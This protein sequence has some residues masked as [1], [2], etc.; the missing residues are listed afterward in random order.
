[1][2]C[3]S[4]A[5]F[6]LRYLTTVLVLLASALQAQSSGPNQSA[7]QGQPHLFGPGVISTSDF[8]FNASFTPDGKTV[9][10]S[11]SD[12]GFNRITIV[13]SH[14]KGN[15]WT[16]PEVAPFSGIWKDTDPRVSPDGKKLFFTSNRPVDGSNTPKG[17]YDIWY[18]DRIPAK[19]WSE[20]KHLGAPVNSD[21]NEWYASVTREGTLYFGAERA[22]HPGTHIYRSRLVDGEYRPPELL[23]FSNQGNDLDPSIAA[24][25]SFVIFISRDRSG[26]GAG[27]LYVSFHRPDGTWSTPK[28]LGSPINSSFHEIATGLS[29]DNRILYFASNRIDGPLTRAARV[30]YR[31]L[32]HGLYAIQNGLLNIYEVDISDLDR[33][34]DAR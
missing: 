31:Q 32:E 6:V 15:D 26:M 14:R 18:V 23:P 22:D 11:K 12:P 34:D 16:K 7:L 28:N 5:A 2:D 29:P 13:L 21:G 19:G 1:M 25:D 30:N 24:D 27:D 9:Y 20:P 17:D 33:L 8:E 4:A 3:D 10:F